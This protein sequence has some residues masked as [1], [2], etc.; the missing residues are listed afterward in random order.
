MFERTRRIQRRMVVIAERDVLSGS[1]TL[2][3]SAGE[4]HDRGHDD[5]EFHVE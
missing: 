5:A 4:Q 1:L 2:S 3:G